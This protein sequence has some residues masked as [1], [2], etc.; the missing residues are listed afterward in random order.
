M[1][2]RQR[3]FMSARYRLT[4]LMLL[5]LLYPLTLPGVVFSPQT[6]ED[7][8]NQGNAERNKREWDAAID[9]F[10]K[11]IQL[12]PNYAEAYYNRGVLRHARSDLDG[13]IADFTKAIELDPKY[14]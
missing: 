1:F 4:F 12:N 14:A 7:Y 3:N 6:A 11:A 2:N 13:A 10:T 5:A 9:D 8:V